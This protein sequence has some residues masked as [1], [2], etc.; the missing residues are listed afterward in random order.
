MPAAKQKPGT[1]V[2]PT[3]NM[4]KLNRPAPQ[5]TRRPGS[6]ASSS[7]RGGDIPAL[8]EPGPDDSVAGEEDPGAGLDLA[9]DLARPQP[10]V[11]RPAKTPDP[12]AA[13]HRAPAPVAPGNPSVPGAPDP[14]GAAPERRS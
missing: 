9:N 13:G 6:S 3:V 8:P 11:A 10:P 7:S 1:P 14:A 4:I 12:A 2:A 5:D